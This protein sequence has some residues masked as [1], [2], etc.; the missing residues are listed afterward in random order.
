MNNSVS[1]QQALVTEQFYNWEL[2]G[3][4][5]FCYDHPVELEPQFTPF[6]GHTVVKKQIVDDGTSHTLLSAFASL[7]T[8]KS[9]PEEKAVTPEVTYDPILYEAED[10]LIAFALV[11]PKGFKAGTA[12]TFTFLT[13]L[14]Y[15][16]RPLSYEIH[17]NAD[18]MQVK[19]VCREE[20]AD[21]IH[22][23]LKTYFPAIGII[24]Q[25]ELYDGVL[26]IDMPLATVDFGLEQEFMRPLPAY[27]AKEPDSLTG[28][29]SVC[30]HLRNEERVLI[31]VL[32]NGVVNAWTPSIL[33][34][35]VTRNG[36]SFFEDAPEM[37]GMAK[38]KTQSPLYAC[39]IRVVAQ[40]ET[41]YRSEQ[42][43]DNLVF[44]LHMQTKSAANSLVPLYTEA[45]SIKTRAQDIV[46]RQSHRSGML[47]NI[48]ELAQFF[49]FP[50]ML[51]TLSKLY[52]KERK[53]KA[54]PSIAR[55]HKTILGVNRYLGR[56]E[57]VTVSMEQRLKHTHIIGAT[58]T[59][60]STLIAR[61]LVQDIEAGNGIAL[62]DPHG[63]LV[64][65]ILGRIPEHRMKDVVVIDPSDT[66][67]PVGIN[68]LQA[69]SEI[70]KEIL[71]SDVVASF[72]RQSTSWGDQM[73]AVFGNAILAFLESS[74]GGSLHDLRRFLVEREYR[75]KILATVKDPAIHYY[76]QKEYPLL[77]TNSI[78]PILTRI[79]TFLRPR[80]LRN[81]VMQKSGINFSEVL[82][83]KKILLVKLS[84]GLIGA[85]NSYLLGSLILSK[86]HQA[87]FARQQ[88]NADRHPF[89][90]YIDECQ[91]FITPSI[92]EML[93]GVRKY[94]VGLVL[95]HQDLQQ[96]QNQDSDLLLSDVGI[97]IV[98]RIG[99]QDAKKL[100][101]GFSSFEPVDFQNL[102][103]G[104]SIIRIEQP[105]YD[106]TLDTISL[107]EVSPE[108][109]QVK[110][111]Q[112]IAHSR[113]KYAMTKEQV[114]E[115]LDDAF[116]IESTIAVEPVTVSK[117]NEKIPSEPDKKSLSIEIKEVVKTAKI[118]VE[119]KEKEQVSTHRY[120]QTLIKKMAESKGYTATLEASIPDSN[121]Q[122][123]VLLTKEGKRMAVEISVTTDAVWEMH[124][125]E[126]CCMAG[127][128]QIVSVSGDQK[129]LE[130]IKAQCEA[131]I[132]NFTQYAVLFLT[133]DAL[134]ALLDEQSSSAPEPQEQTM[135]GYR[136]KVRYDSIS[137]EEVQRKR[138]AVAKVVMDSLRK[139]KK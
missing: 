131:G 48:H 110:R 86:L 18:T 61:L 13:M 100:S 69:H 30:E 105:Q 38:E 39:T 89:F 111:E 114:A 57:E 27:Q 115:M 53:T 54:V 129:Q 59:G 83:T 138:S 32:C 82:Q 120:L 70:E 132:T 33:R 56:E 1:T 139:Q 35:V 7:F 63:D 91:H 3:R 77:K 104:E 75:N 28:M 106:T 64:E 94:N 74:S 14:S 124:N 71:S 130:K 119:T 127:Y 15:V 66:D 2:L 58:G 79:D 107:E 4:G 60:K 109:K 125:I 37:P 50:T 81:M 44:S 137:Q 51:S 76:W 112:I 118:A 87:A 117:K 26:D 40:A 122:V 17:A 34:S 29:L 108:E 52:R 99:N 55:G 22:I 16:T 123:D 65:E 45:Y 102:G 88:H 134:F 126:K 67:Y 8:S 31:Q 128:E 135:K 11:I 93:T 80:L 90:I 23:Q 95:S 12:D 9:K 116:A 84:Q 6:F 49:H 24:P 121:A 136:V 5:W 96:V 25:M 97:R 103:R 92:R 113:A 78:G 133:P 42:L 98:F 20:D 10:V 19:I 46:F 36:K 72:K 62:F 41:D 85:E 43:L 47:L 68:I 21:Y 101:E 73:N